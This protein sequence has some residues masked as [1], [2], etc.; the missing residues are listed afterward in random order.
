MIG[1][2]RADIIPINHHITSDK[3]CRFVA[4]DFF[5]LVQSKNGFDLDNACRRLHAIL[6]DIYYSPKQW[7][8]V[9]NYFFI[10][11]MAS[12]RFPNISFQSAYLESGRMML[13]M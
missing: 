9:A 11:K 1:W 2:Q 5:E 10:R 3:R 12:Q 13:L 6:V 8:A 7:L 4:G